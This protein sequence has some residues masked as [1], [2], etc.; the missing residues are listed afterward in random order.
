MESVRTFLGMMNFVC[1]SWLTV[2][3]ALQPFSIEVQN[4][5]HYLSGLL[6]SFKVSAYILPLGMDREM[7]I[8]FIEQMSQGFKANSFAESEMIADRYQGELF[9][10]SD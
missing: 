7:L 6:D 1:W 5:E 8:H 4:V 2:Q 9:L 10:S 3:I